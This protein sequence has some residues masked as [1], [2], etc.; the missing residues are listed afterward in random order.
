[1]IAKLTKLDSIQ[2]AADGTVFAVFDKQ[3]VEGDRVLLSEKQSAG[4]APGEDFQTRL[5]EVNAQFVAQGFAACTSYGKLSA[6]INVA[7]DPAT[8]ADF[9]AKQAKDAEGAQDA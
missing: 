7:Q 2:I 5:D 9:K 3:L 1:M 4:F 6:Y 8:V